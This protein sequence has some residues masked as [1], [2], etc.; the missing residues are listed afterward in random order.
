[1][2][3][4]LLTPFLSLLGLGL[5][6]AASAAPPQWTLNT[7]VSGGGNGSITSDVGS[8][9]CGASCSSVYNNGTHVSLIAYAKP[10]SHFDH[11]SG[12]CT[13][14]VDIID[15]LMTSN[16]SCKAHFCADGYADGVFDFG[17]ARGLQI[18]RDNTSFVN[19]DSLAV[20]GVLPA[21]LDGDGK[22]E[23]VIDYGDTY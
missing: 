10:G 5:A 18:F 23:L 20:D 8:I 4:K 15:V 11:W 21:D 1:M 19:L 3:K 9:N 17:G 22:A 2:R 14:T 7:Q 16:K 13:G 12:S 6:V